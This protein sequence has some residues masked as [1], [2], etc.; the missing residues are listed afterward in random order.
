M[1]EENLDA[2]VLFGTFHSPAYLMYVANY[3]PFDTG[4]AVTLPLDGDRDPTM[5]VSDNQ[6]QPNDVSWLDDIEHI[7]YRDLSIRNISEYITDSV[8][9]LDG[10]DRVGLVGQSLVSYQ[11][12]TQLSESLDGIEVVDASDLVN[13][14]MSVKSDREIALLRRAAEITDE[15]MQSTLEEELVGMTEYEIANHIDAQWAEYDAIPFNLSQQMITTGPVGGP[16]GNQW[17]TDRTVTEEDILSLDSHCIY[18][19]YWSDLAR[20]IPMAEAS[21]EKVDLVRQSRNTVEHT[22]EHVEPGVTAGS[23]HRIAETYLTDWNDDVDYRIIHHPVG[24]PFI[25]N[26]WLAPDQP[27]GGKNITSGA[28]FELQPNMV[29]SIAC[30]VSKG[31]DRAF[32][33]S[34][35]RVTETGVEPLT[36]MPLA[37]DY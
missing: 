7:G 27:M 29:Y 16:N 19:G 20:S 25:G 6:K 23:I 13:R 12:P 30:E 36:N 26:P 31:D 15:V 33:E 14:T 1:D 5:F 17:V 34:V 8:Q 22:I 9:S 3:W 32:L 4:G 11:L 18:S 35:V 24:L 21:E 2:L 37:P 10:V 28:T